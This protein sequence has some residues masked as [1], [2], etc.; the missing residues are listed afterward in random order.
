[1][2]GLSESE[3]PERGLASRS[4]SGNLEIEREVGV[5]VGF[6]ESEYRERGEVSL[7]TSRNLSTGIEVRCHDRLLGIWISAEKSGVISG[8]AG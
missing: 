8:T 7:L 3:Y 4:V 1:M 5:M 6:S 2:I